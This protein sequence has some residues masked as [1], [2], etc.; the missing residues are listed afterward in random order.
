MDSQTKPSP[1]GSG[2]TAQDDRY[3]VTAHSL[4]LQLPC[5]HFRKPPAS[6][7]DFDQSGTELIWFLCTSP[8]TSA[9]DNRWLIADSMDVGHG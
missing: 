3:G 8:R 9:S 6:N 7:D 5:R 1:S 4:S 2:L